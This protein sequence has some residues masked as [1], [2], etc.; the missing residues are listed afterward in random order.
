MN[1]FFGLQKR[2]IFFLKKK[3][4]YICSILVLLTIALI[5]IKILSYGF[6][7]LDDAK[8]HCAFAVAEKDWTNILLMKKEYS[9]EH[10]PGWDYIL[11]ILHKLGLDKY[12]L[13][14][15]SV[16]FYFIIFNIIGIIITKNALSWLNAIALESIFIGI[17]IERIISGR[18]FIATTIAVILLYF[19]NNSNNL[20]ISQKA[21]YCLSTLFI[22]IAVW[23]HGSWYLFLIVPFTYFLAGKIKES[24]KLFIVIILATI[25][26]ASLSG[27]LTNFLYYHYHIPID[28]FTEKIPVWC[29]A[30]EFQPMYPSFAWMFP[31]FAILAINIKNKKNTLKQLFRSPEIILLLLSWCLGIYKR[32]FW[33]DFT[34]PIYIYILAIQLKDIYS[35]YLKEN[36]IRVKY[37]IL[38]FICLI[39][40]FSYTHDTNGRFSKRLLDN[41]P[42]DFNIE[43][44]KTWKPGKNGIIYSDRMITYYTHFFEYPNENWKY[45]LGYEAAV[46]TNE[47]KKIYRAI[48]Y[49]KQPNNYMPWV[50]KMNNDDRLIL[51][52][53]YIPE[54]PGIEWIQ[55]S[56]NYFIGRKVNK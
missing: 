13:L 9:F 17:Y 27:Q 54:L 37:I 12:D 52:N 3:Y 28:I 32:R 40:Y 45:V 19:I 48:Q 42:I 44:L 4:S 55:G 1:N 38:F 39:T 49:S 23:I 24:L 50:E 7:P 6:Y 34:C 10:S 51:Y 30:E 53:K 2:V 43:K 25:I 31:L 35:V 26:G 20:K 33:Y 16:I 15:F 11:R 14:D 36:S 18:P 29:L 56:R 22:S 21:I 8:R 47:N 46:M 5:P 41:M